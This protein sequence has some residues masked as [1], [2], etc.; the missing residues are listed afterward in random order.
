MLKYLILIIR[1]CCQN[2]SILWI[3]PT[4]HIPVTCWD[5]KY[6]VF[7]LTEI[8]NIKNSNFSWY[9]KVFFFNLYFPQFIFLYWWNVNNKFFWVN[10]KRF[11]ENWAIMNVHKENFTWALFKQC[12]F[13][14]VINIF[15]F[16]N[17]SI[18]FEFRLQLRFYVSFNFLWFAFQ[19]LQYNSF[20]NYVISKLFP[21][22]VSV[23]IDIDFVKKLC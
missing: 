23:S 8:K 20:L 4:P 6:F 13:L 17:E 3:F 5:K 9:L 7:Y 12:N 11:G 15:C 22:H 16:M 1:L 21:F 18:N 19:I 10:L 14:Y 2:K